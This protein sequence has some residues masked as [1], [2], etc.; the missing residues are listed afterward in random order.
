MNDLSKI[1]KRDLTTL[2]GIVKGPGWYATPSEDKLDRL[3]QQGLIKK[4]R[5]GWGPTLKGRIVV[6]I[7]RFRD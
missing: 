5:R 7:S 6:W 3:L 1:E 4:K 2:A